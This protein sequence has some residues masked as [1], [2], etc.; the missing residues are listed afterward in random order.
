MA[1]RID[2]PAKC[3]LGSVIH[4][5]QAQGWLVENDQCGCFLSDFRRLRIAILISGD[6]LIHD[7][8]RPQR[9]VAT[10]HLLEQFKSRYPA[11][12]PDFAPSDFHL[13]PEMKNWQGG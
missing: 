10:Q 12:S 5:F 9:A 13:C 3:E 2:A 7:N 1:G 4:F 6:V 8:V 11:Y